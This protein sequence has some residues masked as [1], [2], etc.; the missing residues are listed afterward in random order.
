LLPALQDLWKIVSGTFLEVWAEVSAAFKEAG[1]GSRVT[2]SDIRKG[3]LAVV[4]QAGPIIA[5]LIRAIG[6]IVLWF[7]RWKD[8]ILPL[9]VAIGTFVAG[10]MAVQKIIAVI[11]AVKAA[12]LALN[13]VFAA[14][15]IG[16]IITGIAAL[17]AG[18]IYFFTQ[19]ETGRKLWSK[20][21]TAVRDLWGK[22]V[23]WFQTTWS[24]V[25]AFFANIGKGVQSV[26]N[27]F[28]QLPSKI[29]SFFGGVVNWLI[30][31]GKNLISGL[32]NGVKNRWSAVTS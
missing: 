31:A 4:K 18:L 6:D 9:V 32:L 15:P 26:I 23:S 7:I 2:A 1:D 17:V 29:K 3:I 22:V 19:T 5:G 21:T 30:N 27:W 10:F 11:K 25:A 16:L 13:L 24:K 8:I 14:S 28:K 20:F 12:W